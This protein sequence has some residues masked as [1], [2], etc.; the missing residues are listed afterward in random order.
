MDRGTEKTT[1]VNIFGEELGIRSQASP[2]YTRR[3]AA[4]VDKAMKQV[5]NATHVTDVHRI[6]ILAAMSITD[7]FFQARDRLGKTNRMWESRVGEILR[8]LRE[9]GRGAGDGNG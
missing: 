5:A 3:V 7:E 6:A 9:D 4:Y 1:R 2:E 8:A